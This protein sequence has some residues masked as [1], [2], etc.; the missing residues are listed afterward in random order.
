M[1]I[2]GLTTQR[3]LP[4]LGKIRTGIKVSNDAGVEYPRAVDYFVSPPEVHAVF[5]EKPTVLDIMLPVDS[6]EL[7]A[8]AYY[9]AYSISRGLV[10]RRD[11]VNANRLIDSARKSAEPDT[12][13]VT[14]PIAD[15]EAQ[16][17]EWVTNITC[18]GRD[19][20]YY[21]PGQTKQCREVMA[22]Q[23]LIPSVPGL[24]VWQLDTGSYHSIVN[25]YSGLELIRGMFGAV[26]MIPLQLS[27][28]PME[29]SPDGRKK[30]VH[31][32][33]L[34]SGQTLAGIAEQKR[35]PMG[36]NLLPVPDETREEL[37]F[38][39]HGY[40]NGQ[41]AALPPAETAS[42]VFDAGPTPPAEP[43]Q[44]VAPAGPNKA[45]AKQW[46]ERL[47]DGTDPIVA[48]M[49]RDQ[50]QQMIDHIGIED[51]SLL[52]DGQTVDQIQNSA[53]KKWTNYTVAKRLA[54]AVLA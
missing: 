39:E 38:P 16:A 2:Q 35:Q 28:E 8:P 26:A 10:C 41:S 27:L 12:G 6:D 7:V 43:K 34:R 1:P 42:S 9:K 31:V 22:L 20:S 40:E 19:C 52:L 53:P 32:L 54:Q 51:V 36:A 24:G 37:L 18:P 25:I 45:R 44:A 13:V 5:G 50:L 11:G 21:E 49:G 4:R 3:R 48:N 14:G 29:V 46:M 15:R 17:T 47:G 30:T 33:H 23:F